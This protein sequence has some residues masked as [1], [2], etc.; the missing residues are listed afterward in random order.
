VESILKTT[1]DELSRALGAR[2]ATM[3][4][5]P[6]LVDAAD[7]D[8]V[9]NGDSDE[10]SSSMTD[11]VNIVSSRDNVADLASPNWDVPIEMMAPDPPGGEA[12]E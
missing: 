11:K 2:R 7:K 4:I 6:Q 3:R 10:E 5:D 9:P 8:I 12:I 1:T